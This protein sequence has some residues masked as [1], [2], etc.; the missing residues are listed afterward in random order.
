MAERLG[1]AVV[2]VGIY[3]ANHVRVYQNHPDTE[4]IVVWSRSQAR[5]GRWPKYG[6]A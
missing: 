3:G 2:G 4:L 1:A 5:A 6:C